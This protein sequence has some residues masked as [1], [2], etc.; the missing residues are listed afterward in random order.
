MQGKRASRTASMGG[1]KGKKVQEGGGGEA[2]VAL[3]YE[4]ADAIRCGETG[5]RADRRQKGDSAQDPCQARP[6]LTRL[7]TVRFGVRDQHD[8]C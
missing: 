5:E 3:S 1:E 6:N 7:R 4:G 8:L 2:E